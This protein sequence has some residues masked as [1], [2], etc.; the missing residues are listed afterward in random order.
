M[1]AGLALV[2]GFL[3]V[4]AATLGFVVHAVR[5]A[6]PRAVMPFLAFVAVWLAVLAVLASRGVFEDLPLPAAGAPLL[7]LIVLAQLVPASRRFC[8]QL[9]LPTLIDVMIDR[10]RPIESLLLQFALPPMEQRGAQAQPGGIAHP[11]AGNYKGVVRSLQDARTSRA[12]EWISALNTPAPDYSMTDLSGGGGSPT[13]TAPPRVSQQ[14]Q[15]PPPSRPT[16]T[17][18][19]RR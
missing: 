4:V 6:S 5:K 15:P 13:N 3:L 17:P 11:N 8:D 16:T 14:T 1:D 19:Q 12:L 7:I 9:P 18:A 2:I 10:D